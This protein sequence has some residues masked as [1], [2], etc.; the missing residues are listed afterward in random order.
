MII[1]NELVILIKQSIFEN[2]Q[3]NG[4]NIKEYISSIFAN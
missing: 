1:D 2:F 4:L 3:E